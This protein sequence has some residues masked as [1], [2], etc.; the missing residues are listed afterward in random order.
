MRR[1]PRITYRDLSEQLGTSTPNVHRRIDRLRTTGTLGPIR[2][3]LR[4]ETVGGTCALIHGQAVGKLDAKAWQ[5]LAAQGSISRAII[6]CR[7]RV[8]LST[9]L[10][11]PSRIDEVMRYL[12]DRFPIAGPEVLVV[13]ERSSPWRDDW[14]YSG[15]E[16]GPRM[17]YI[18]AADLRII[19]SM[20]DD[21]RKQICDI[22]A[23]TGLSKPTVRRRLANLLDRK[24]IEFD[25]GIE[26]GQGADVNFGL[27][28]RFQSPDD[29]DG[30]LRG[31]SN[32]PYCCREEVMLFSNAPDTVWM[33]LTVDTINDGYARI[34]E[35]RERK[36]VVSVMSDVILKAFTFETW[37]D[38]L[39]GTEGGDVVLDDRAAGGTLRSWAHS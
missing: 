25:M 30:F 38:R 15:D 22:A 39:V 7:D 32:E 2:A 28:V 27:I 11:E 19:R 13:Q 35:I 20:W 8:Y 4:P 1:E 34:D 23:D 17:E 26:H 3:K 5:A 24:V 6:G 31:L 21:G 14:T 29:R 16:A 9:C 37:V 36:G 12:A 18:R 10:K 33:N